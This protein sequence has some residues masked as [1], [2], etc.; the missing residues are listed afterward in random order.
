MR[1]LLLLVVGAIVA[2]GL[3]TWVVVSLSKKS[4]F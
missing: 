2:L 4:N 1:T 3:I